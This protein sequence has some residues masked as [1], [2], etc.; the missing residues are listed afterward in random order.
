MATNEEVSLNEPHA[1]KPLAIEAFQVVEPKIKQEIVRSRHDWDKHEPRMWAAV[2]HLSDQELTA[3]DVSKDL[4][5][6]RSAVVSYGTIILGKIRIP[7]LDDG[8]VH[9]RIHDPPNRG[10]EDIS[11]HSLFTDEGPVEKNDRHTRWN[12]IQKLDTPLEFFNE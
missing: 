4:V 11:F 8:Y 10:T 7:A 1:P 5:V 12:A 6:V 9:V 3:F 2:K